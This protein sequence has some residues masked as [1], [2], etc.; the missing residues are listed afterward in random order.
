VL[1]SQGDLQAPLIEAGVSVS[2]VAQEWWAYTGFVPN[3]NYRIR[4]LAAHLVAAGK[5]VRLF[6]E[7]RPDL[8]VTNTVT[9]PSG[10]VAAKLAGVPHVWYVHE[11]IG[12]E[13]HDR[14]GFDIGNSVSL[15]LI[16]K[17][18]RKIIVNSAVVRRSLEGKIEQ[19][20]LELIYY[21]VDTPEL[22]DKSGERGNTF[23]V[24]LVGRMTSGKGQ[25]DAIRALSVLVAKDF[26]VRLTLIGNED[27]RY[28]KSLEALVGQLGIRH[29]VDFVPFTRDPFSWVCSSDLALMCSR[30]EP[31]GR[32][33]V[34]AM[35]MG[36]PV[37]GAIGHGTSELI[38]DGWNGFLYRPGDAEHL[39]EKIQRLY[40][41]RKLLGE[42]AD[43]ATQ[44]ARREFT[45]ERYG[46][47]LL[48][49]FEQTVTANGLPDG[50]WK[51][52]SWC[53]VGEIESERRE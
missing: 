28:R 23:R 8:V 37:I 16:D 4:R 50:K 20:K 46:R 12:G 5:L 29:R 6:K 32:V 48:R 43:N 18:S 17:L 26:D 45:V 51:K 21:G 13:G 52:Q 19:G 47:A 36:K 24:V 3:L 33:T 15:S 44:W 34:E 53:S 10:A 35:K 31:F 27:P 11:L 1:P 7:V 22:P 49:L 30:G 41:D 14:F 25:E 38:R 39:A 2:T 40:V 9:I 42:M